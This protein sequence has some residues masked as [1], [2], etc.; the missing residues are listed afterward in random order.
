MA[1]QILHIDMNSYFATVEQQANPHLR[2]KPVAVLGSKAKRTII[3]ASSIEAKRFGV[4]TTDTLQEGVEKCP[5]LTIVHGEPRKYSYVTK[6]FIHIFERYTDKVEIF[7]IDEAFL[8]VTESSHLFGGP[9][10]MAGKIKENIRKE[11]GGWISCSVGIASNKFLAKTGSDLEKPDGLVVID[12]KNKDKILLDLP[13]KEFCGIGPRVLARLDLLG[14]RNVRDLR[15][16]PDISL[17]REF[18]IV[19]SRHL[20]AMAHGIDSSP[21]ISWRERAPAKSFSCSR[22]LNKDVWKRTEVEKQILFLFEK[23]AKNLRDDGYWAKEVGLW[24]RFKDFTGMARTVRLGYWVCDSFVFY[25]KTLEIL[26]ATTIRQPVRAIGVYAG[27]VQKSQNVPMSILKE[28][29]VNEK[30]L[31]TMDG[32]NN[33]FGEDVITRGRLAGVKLKEIVSGMGRDKF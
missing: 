7:S 33:R 2:G 22:T 28:D 4:K 24:L 29:R 16:F 18:G 21:V 31:K 27:K 20:K 11:I 23:V 1:R 10:Q 13:L 32:I 6:K 14:I 30:V 17:K 12:D 8:D 19:R 5:H 15:G 26:D 25:K 3:V 9:V